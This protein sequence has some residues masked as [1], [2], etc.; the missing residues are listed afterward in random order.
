MV[1]FI[2]FLSF[3]LVSP[4]MTHLSENNPLL[5]QRH[6]A[7]LG[8]DAISE[9]VGFSNDDTRLRGEISLTSS[10]KKIIF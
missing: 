4:T 8:L 9:R 3:K 2:A 1:C 10:G 6:S 5:P 7:R